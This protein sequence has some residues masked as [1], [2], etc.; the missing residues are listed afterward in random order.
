[1]KHEYK[2]PFI[3][4]YTDEIKET[5]KRE[6]L[7]EQKI[8]ITGETTADELMDYIKEAYKKMNVNEDTLMIITIKKVD[9]EEYNR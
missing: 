6:L 1:M 7:D 8:Y 4:P 9:A 5:E 2:E 3:D